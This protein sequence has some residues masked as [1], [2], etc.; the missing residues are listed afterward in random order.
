MVTLRGLLSGRTWRSPRALGAVVVIAWAVLSVGFAPS[1]RGDEAT[2][3]TPEATTATAASAAATAGESSVDAERLFALKIYPLLQSKCFGCHGDDA[4]DLKGDLDLRT[5]EATLAGGESEEPAM[6]PGHAADQSI[7]YQ[8]VIWD[9]YE[10]PPKENDRLTPEQCEWVRVWIEAGA[11]W[12]EAD[13][14]SELRREDWSRLETE[15]GRIITTSG[16]QSEEWTYRRYDPQS[17]WAFQR[18]SKPDVPAVAGVEAATIANPVDAF[19]QARQAA[20]GVQPAPPAEPRDLIRRVTYDL[21]GLPPTP[22]EVADFEAANAIDAERAWADLVERLLASPHYGERMAQHWLDVARYADTGGLSNDY[23]RSNAWRYRDWVVRAFNA[24]LPYD[25]FIRSQI[26]GDELAEAGQLPE[27]ARVATGFLRMGPWDTAMIPAEEARQLFLDDVVH[28][29]GQAFLSMPMRCCKCHDHKFDPVPTRDYYRLYAAFAT[30]Q[31][32][33]M[34]ADFLPEENRQG[35]ETERAFVQ[36]MLDFADGE[37]KRLQQKREDAAA[38]WYAEHGLPYKNWNDRKDD[39]DDEKP[40]RHVGLSEAEQG[41]LKVREQDVW[42]WTRRLERVEPM[43]QSVVNAQT[44]KWTNARKLR[45]PKSV[46]E[47]FD[48]MVQILA[49]GSLAAAG[50]TVRPGVLSGPGLPVPRA[51]AAEAANRTE[52]GS[53]TSKS[54]EAK[55]DDAGADP[56]LTTT[57]LSGRRTDVANWIAHPDNP[58]TTR[59]MAN[60]IWQMHFGRGLVGTPNNFGVKGD[61]PTHPQLLDWLAATFVEDGW[62]VKQ[63]HRR[64]LTSRAYRQSTQHPDAERLAEIDPAN[65][66]LARALPR[67]LT[68]EEVRDS[69]LA[70][71][72]E[73]NRQ[74]GGLPARPEINMEVALQP[75]MIQ[76]SLAPAYQPSATPPERNRRSLYAYRV[77]GQAD[78]MME[79]LNLPNPNDS[80]ERRNSA[81]VTPQAFTLFNSTATTDRAIALAQ[82][83]QQ[84]HSTPEQQIAAAFSL[85]LGRPASDEEVHQL[86]SYTSEMVQHHAAVQPLP[87]HYPQEITRSLVEELSGQPFEYTEILPVFGTYQPDAKPADVSPATRALA[88]VCL[89]LFNT[90]EFMYLY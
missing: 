18:V 81:A 78:P 76:F 74:V 69:M 31:P 28:S 23:E 67:R 33:E 90:N 11:P 25:A 70:V 30:S 66:L 46:D 47:A 63:L 26:A 8:A 54:P 2:D 19:L 38:A 9:G 72:G 21:T 87:V 22:Q 42:I 58:L 10:M 57:A 60:R 40:A 83:L 75:R 86:A 41:V 55:V 32:A 65:T 5:L 51:N 14:R 12:P 49:G 82:R 13:R 64:L 15:D 48:P 35:F 61:Q 29:V 34:T 16:G 7:L 71:S 88:D 80:C 4:A 89:V 45:A 37:A 6:V 1:A 79:V 3:A 52:A 68:A 59:T 27:A 85:V 62:S 17:V 44:S 77:R 43:I 50:E 73:L 39:P 24:D 53:Q 20:A 56:F 84:E 36:T